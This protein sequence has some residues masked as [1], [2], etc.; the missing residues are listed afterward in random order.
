MG[1]NR[2]SSRNPQLS[3]DLEVTG[4]DSGRKAPLPKFRASGDVEAVVIKGERFSI[5]GEMTQTLRKKVMGVLGSGVIE[6]IDPLAKTRVTD[7]QDEVWALQEELAAARRDAEASREMLAQSVAGGVWRRVLDDPEEMLV[8]LSAQRN[9]STV[10]A[11]RAI[12]A[13]YAG[14]MSQTRIAQLANVSQAHVSRTVALL[15]DH[16]Q[17]LDE[18]PEEVAWR[19][20]AGEI[21]AEE[22]VQ[23]LVDWPYTKG[24][25]HDDAYEAGTLDQLTTLLAEGFL[26]KE[27]FTII[28][29]HARNRG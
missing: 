5:T 23:T 27:Q 17:L 7:A 6:V 8:A 12:H 29:A 25:T 19:H 11:R 24:R 15:G 1:K 22:M 2:R 21:A 18:T 14:G 16:P 9:L 20:A 4:T 10:R 13:L 26:T 3:T 28:S